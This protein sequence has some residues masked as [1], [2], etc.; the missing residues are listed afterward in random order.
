MIKFIND[1][2]VEVYNLQDD[3]E[4]QNDLASQ[5][6]DIAEKGLAYMKAARTTSEIDIWEF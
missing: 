6:P 2:H 5:K 4:E 1:D 3:L